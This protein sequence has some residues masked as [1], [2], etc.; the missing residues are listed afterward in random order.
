MLDPA[1][2]GDSG[3]LSG[4]SAIRSVGQGHAA[5]SLEV[6]VEYRGSAGGPLAAP[7]YVQWNVALWDDAVLVCKQIAGVQASPLVLTHVPIHLCLYV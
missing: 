3:G 1:G 2:S 7:A 6:K 5:W 4:S